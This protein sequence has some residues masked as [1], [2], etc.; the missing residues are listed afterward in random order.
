MLPE[1]KELLDTEDI[2][3]YLNV[4]TKTIYRYIKAR[5]LPA[6]K[7]GKRFKIHR[8]D[9]LKFLEARKLQK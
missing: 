9:F 1:D 4:S 2:V 8:A 7:V 3:R 5:Q 6:M